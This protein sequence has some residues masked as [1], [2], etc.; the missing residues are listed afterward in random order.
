MNTRAVNSS[1]VLA[2]AVL[3][4]SVY[5]HEVGSAKF[6][7]LKLQRRSFTVQDDGRGMGLDRDGYVSGLLE[8]L[9]GRRGEV[10]LHGIGLA[11]VAMSSPMLTVE[12][13][14]GGRLSTQSYSWGIAHGPVESRPA[15]SETG[16]R[17]TV[18]LPSEGPG[19]EIAD[20][21]GQVEAWRAS[22]PELTI[23]VVDEEHAP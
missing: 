16:T 2:K 6:V 5:E 10:A 22:H 3:A 8:Q 9:S 1:S 12:S 14:R 18:A 4:Y 11:I 13:R 20:V 17:V 15:G 19:I 21:L 23:E 7:Q